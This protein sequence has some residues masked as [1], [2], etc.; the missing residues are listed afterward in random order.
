MTRKKPWIA[1]VQLTWWNI[2]KERNSRVFN[3]SAASLSRIH[4]HI[5]EEARTWKDA[6]RS[7]AFDL[8]QRPREPD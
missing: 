3:N 6:G 5:L 8:L 2:W 7:N 4:T 1:L